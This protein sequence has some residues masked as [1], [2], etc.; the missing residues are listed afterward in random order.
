MKLLRDS[1][2]LFMRELMQTLRNP[3]WLIIG[4]FQPICFLLLFA[5]LLDGIAQAPGFPPGGALNVFTPG[6]LV[7]MGMY[8]AAFVGFGLIADL[9]A[10]VIERLRVTPVS[11]L[12]L[13]LGRAARD[14]LVL[15]VQSLLLI[16][17]AWPMGLRI[18][19]GGIVVAFGLVALIGL[20][21]ASCSYAL[22]LAF[23]SEDALA[24]T[25]NFFIVPLQLLSGITLPLTLAPLW[26]RNIAAFN[27]LSYAVDAAR[28]LFNGTLADG[29]VMRGFGVLVVLALLATWWAAQ[30]FRQA[31]A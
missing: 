23:K 31:T 20:I 10:G 30:S 29:S 5:P 8:G 2:L 4:L 27:P 28:S 11:R 19:V 26:I 25:I 6:L 16:L 12:A 13:L 3:V 14:V 18:N 7:M 22:A 17:A 9:R 15:V 24:P 1:W 21:L